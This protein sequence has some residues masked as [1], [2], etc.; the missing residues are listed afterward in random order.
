MPAGPALEAFYGMCSDE[1]ATWAVERATADV[2]EIEA[3][4]SPFLSATSEL[5]GLL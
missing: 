5:E 2:L 1:Q 3:D 4:H